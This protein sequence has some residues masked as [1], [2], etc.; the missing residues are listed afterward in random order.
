MGELS[1]NKNLILIE[2]ENENNKNEMNIEKNVERVE[3]G[4]VQM[5]NY[6]IKK[7]V[8]QIMKK[9]CKNYKFIRKIWRGHNINGL[10]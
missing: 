8:K 1:Q 5:E 4:N 7:N 2:E 10:C 9:F 6:K 3:S